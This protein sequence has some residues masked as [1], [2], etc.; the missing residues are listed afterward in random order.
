VRD[1]VVRSRSRLFAFRDGSQVRC[2]VS[3]SDSAIRATA[4]AST[5]GAGQTRRLR[6]IAVLTGTVAWGSRCRRQM[7]SWSRSCWRTSLRSGRCC[8]MWLKHRHICARSH[9][10]AAHVPVD[11]FDCTPRQAHF[12]CNHLPHLLLEPIV[13]SGQL[14]LLLLVPILTLLAVV[15][16]AQPT[17]DRAATRQTLRNI[18]PLHPSAAQLDS[19]LI[20]LRRPLSLLL[21][22][23]LRIRR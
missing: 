7:W 18:I 10:F 6:S 15:L 9:F 14:V 23:T 16:V 17:A 19:K 5:S 11:A 12:F 3:S 13:E 22:R 2:C 4:C 20:L 21:W 8:C 1:G